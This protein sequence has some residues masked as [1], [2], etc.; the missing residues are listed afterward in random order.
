M[1]GTGHW[2]FTLPQCNLNHEPHTPGVYKQQRKPCC[3]GPPPGE[4]THPWWRSIVIRVQHCTSRKK[5]RLSVG[6]AT[7][8]L[9]T[10]TEGETE[11]GEPLVETHK[12]KWLTQN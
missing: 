5:P 11:L 8:A 10:R 2:R 3:H 1:N 9:E 4:A 6:Q 12:Q 7:G